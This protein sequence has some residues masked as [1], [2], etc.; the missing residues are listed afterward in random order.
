MLRDRKEVSFISLVGKV[1][2]SIELLS[3][4]ENAKD[5]IVF[6][7]DTKEKYGLYYDRA[8]LKNICD[9][10]DLLDMPILMALDRL[11]VNVRSG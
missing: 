6:T 11:R 7:T 5:E 2:V 8:C 4:S 10:G 3:K 1:V 9:L